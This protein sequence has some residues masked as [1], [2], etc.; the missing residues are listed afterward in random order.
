[1][2][3]PDKQQ[4]NSE[5]KVIGKPFKP[6]VS[7]NPNGRPKKGYAIAD[8]IAAKLEGI[9]DE[10]KK[11]NLETIISKITDKALEGDLQAFDRLMDRTVGKAVQYRVEDITISESPFEKFNKDL[12][13]NK[14]E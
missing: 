6:G 9:D 8:I 4:D 5:K 7:G 12:E 2:D 11:S 10:S 3:N 13:D 1:M 14:G